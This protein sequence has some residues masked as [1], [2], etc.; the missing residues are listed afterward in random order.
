MAKWGEGDPRWIVEERAD[1]TNVNN[2]HWSEKNATPWS[3]N[4]LRELLTGF[5][6]EDGPIVITIDE[7]KKIDGEATANNRKA[8]LIFLFEWVVEGTFI[9]R[10]SGSEDEYK[11]KFDIPNLSDENEAS[12]VDLNTSLDGNGPMAHQIRQVLNKSFVSKIQDVL[13][14]YI[15][16]LKEEFSKGLI[17]PTDQVKPQV[18]TKGKTTTVD[19][20]QFQNTVI[21]EKDASTSGNEV[22]S[23]KEVTVSDTFK[24]TPDRVFEAITVTQFVRGWTN[25]SIQEWNCE[26]GGSFALFGNNVTGTFEKI[27]PN[28]EIVMKWRLKK[29]PNNHHATIRITLHDNGS[30]TDIKFT[31]KDVP[32]HLA[33]ETQNG[34][35]R[36]YLSSISRTFGFSQRM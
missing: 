23:T 9:A 10:V 2:W 31:G 4:R 28:K 1:A 27:E 18:V 6:A 5:S 21:A 12:E 11:G 29:Y 26:E 34:L 19:K 8:K 32:T 33:E 24:A 13:A 25:G 36:Y 35:D 20:R 7:V 16:E 22:F 17:L 3:L 15:R 30:G 14:I